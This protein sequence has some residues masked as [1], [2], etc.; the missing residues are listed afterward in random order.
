M[1]I[2]QIE[3]AKSGIQSLRYDYP[4]VAHSVNPDEIGGAGGV[5]VAQAIKGRTDGI[6]LIEWMTERRPIHWIDQRND[7]L[8]AVH[9]VDRQP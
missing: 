5:T 4:L 8:S 2:R 1:P 6:P 7:P 9:I 3:R